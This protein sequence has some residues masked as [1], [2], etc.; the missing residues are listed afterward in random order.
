MFSSLF[1]ISASLI[2][3]NLNVTVYFFDDIHGEY[4]R[5]CY[6]NI[7]RINFDPPSNTFA[8]F[9]DYMDVKCSSNSLSDRKLV[10]PDL[11]CWSWFIG[12]NLLL[13]YNLYSHVHYRGRFI[14]DKSI[15]TFSHQSIEKL[16]K[17]FEMTELCFCEKFLLV[18]RW[19]L[20]ELLS[21]ILITIVII[22][23]VFYNKYNQFC[24]DVSSIIAGVS[25][26]VSW[27]MLIRFFNFDPNYSSTLRA[28]YRVFPDV[29]RFLACVAI[30]YVAF[31]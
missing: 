12:N 22:M 24:S 13:H 11:C 17:R 28:V 3:I 1:T 19:P 27:S 18:N 9:F 16:F 29:L 23:T 6:T 10:T 25:L 31:L 8:T 14:V 21:N 30:V 20:V 4:H 2:I 15:S 7:F 5:K 26:I